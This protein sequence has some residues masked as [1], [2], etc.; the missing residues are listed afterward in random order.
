MVDGLYQRI[1]VKREA[2]GG[3]GSNKERR[4]LRN[5]QSAGV[6]SKYLVKYLGEYR[7]PGPRRAA[8]VYLEYA[9]YGDLDTLLNY[10]EAQR[11]VNLTNP[12]SLESG[13]AHSVAESLTQLTG[14]SSLSPSSGTC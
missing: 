13:N 8:R 5:L 6:S 10:Y 4:L 2:F 1:V 3:D 11:Q 7:P 12:T 9:P 14:S